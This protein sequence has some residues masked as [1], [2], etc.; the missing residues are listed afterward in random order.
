MRFPPPDFFSVF[1]NSPHGGTPKNVINEIEKKSVLDVLSIF[2][3]KLFGTFF[4]QN[5]FGSVFE[6]PSL[7][8]TRKRD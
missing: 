5:V 3:G 8:N 6:L 2:W 7:R 4:L 1:L